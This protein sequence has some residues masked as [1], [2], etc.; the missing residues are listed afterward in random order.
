MDLRTVDELKRQG[1]FISALNALDAVK[2]AT[3]NAVRVQRIEILE[4]L[5]RHDEC[6]A[7]LEFVRLPSS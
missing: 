4:R 5:G 7:L 1:R 6:R 3:A 2:P